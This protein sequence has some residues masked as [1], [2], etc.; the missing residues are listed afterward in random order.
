MV[1]RRSLRGGVEQHRDQVR[2]RV[3]VLADLAV[4][5]GAGGVEV[6]Q[7]HG[8]Q[9]VGGGVV[10][11]DLLDHPLRAAVGIDRRLWPV[12][13][14]RLA[15]ARAVGGAGA[16]EDDPADAVR[17]HRIQQAKRADDVVA[18]VEPRIEHRLADIGEG[19]EVDD[20]VRT[21]RRQHLGEAVGVEQVAA[22]E[23]APL[24]RMGEAAREVVVGDRRVAGPRQRLAGVR[25]DVARPA[26]DQDRRHAAT[27]SPR[28]AWSCRA[29]WRTARSRPGPPP[30][31]A[32]AR[33][34]PRGC[35]SPARRGSAELR[36]PTRMSTSTRGTWTAVKSASSSAR[37]MKS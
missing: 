18:V 37:S 20:R 28:A 2:L 17:A 23:R 30:A 8:A 31:S 21:M 10:A 36:P 14:D 13:G 15:G 19:G 34:A 9:A 25:A 22:L 11:Q 33:P 5:I 35:G 6:A 7:R 26:G 29:A 16:G 1:K 4:R 32:G 3:V 24:H 12:L 27:P